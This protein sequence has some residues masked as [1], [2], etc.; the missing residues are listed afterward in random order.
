MFHHCIS[1]KHMDWE[2]TSDMTII[3]SLLS[4]TDDYASGSQTVGIY[5]KNRRVQAPCTCT[6][7]AFHFLSTSG[8]LTVNLGPIIKFYNYTLGI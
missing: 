3:L 1:S 8:S 4:Y 5:L 6:S 2:N 7:L